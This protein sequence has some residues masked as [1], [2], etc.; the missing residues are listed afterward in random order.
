MAKKRTVKRAKHRKHHRRISGNQPA[1]VSGIRRKRRK[2]KMSGITGN[3]MMDVVLGSLVGAA[4]SVVYEKMAPIQNAKVKHGVQALLGIGA[5]Y[6]GEKKKNSLLLGVGAGITAEALHSVAQDFGVIQ[7]VHD[8]MAG[9]GLTKPDE[10]LIS[11]N[12]T[13][14][15]QPAI[16]SG[17]MHDIMNGTQNIMN[18]PLDYTPMNGDMPSVVN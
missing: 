1:V 16:V 9:M 10:L 15:D 5:I 18:G 12:G 3:D 6:M 2:R 11:M 7:G 14:A 4:V 17:G 8:F 13:M